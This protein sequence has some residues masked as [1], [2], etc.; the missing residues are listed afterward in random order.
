MSSLT[1]FKESEQKNNE[2]FHGS[3]QKETVLRTRICLANWQTGLFWLLSRHLSLTSQK[4][5]RG[6]LHNKPS[7]RT[8]PEAKANDTVRVELET[9]KIMDHV[10]FETGNLVMISPEDLAGMT[11]ITGKLS[12]EKLRGYLPWLFRV[13][14]ML[15]IEEEYMGS[16]GSYYKGSLLSLFNNQFMGTMSRVCFFSWLT[17][18]QRRRFFVEVVETTLAEWVPS[19]TRRSTPAPLRWCTSRCVAVAR[20]QTL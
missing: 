10:K 14:Y 15:N 13:K 7:N 19:P 6:R 18:S 20:R 16:I 9:G 1:F 17:I 2:F 8:T 5:H 3:S 4:T 12:H 11:K